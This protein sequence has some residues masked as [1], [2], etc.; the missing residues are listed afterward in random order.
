MRMATIKKIT[1]VGE[2]M[3]KVE[4]RVA[5]VEKMMVFPQKI[6]NASTL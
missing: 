5:P 3:E 6:K 2:G 1:C 4:P